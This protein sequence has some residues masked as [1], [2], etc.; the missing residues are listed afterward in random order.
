MPRPVHF[1]I[2]ATRA[3]ALVDFY[4]RLFGWTFEPWGPPGTYWLIRTGDAGTPGID[5][6]LVARRGAAPT[7]GQ[8]VNAFVCTVD[9]DDVA[10]SLARVAALG[11]SVAHPRMPIPGVG[12]LGYGKDPDGNLFGMMQ[13]D[14]A[15]A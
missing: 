5:G 2:H 1:E 14:P 15:A 8:A 13:N 12:W 6:G 7:D 3:E 9:V 10:Q 4:G 11:G